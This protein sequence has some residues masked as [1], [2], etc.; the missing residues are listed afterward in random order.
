MT[1]LPDDPERIR[2]PFVPKSTA[3]L[4]PGQFW[5]VP[6]SNGAF[7]CGRVLQMKTVRQAGARTMFLAGL[8]DWCG[9]EPPTSVSIAG[10]RLV[11][12]GEA[13]IKTIVATGGEVLGYRPLEEDALEPLLCVTAHHGGVVQQGY[14]PIRRA[15]PQDQGRYPVLPTWGSMVIALLAERHCCDAR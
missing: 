1:R 2:Y 5:A 14:T 6:L 4:R 9:Q 8:M 10:A 11:T 7:A 15:T 13:H 12:Q 3:S